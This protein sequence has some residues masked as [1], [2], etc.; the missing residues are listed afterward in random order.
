MIT[1]V[2]QVASKLESYKQVLKNKAGSPT[3]EYV[4]LIGV[5]ALVAGLLAAALSGDNNTGIVKTIANK[6]KKI[7]E[8]A[9][10]FQGE[11]NT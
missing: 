2:Q 10:T 4:I 6:I 1:I 11:K 9:T 5:G 8:A 7:I 3:V